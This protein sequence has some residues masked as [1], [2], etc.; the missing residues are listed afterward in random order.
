MLARIKQ[1]I[2]GSEFTR[3]VLTLMSGTTIAQFIPFLVSPII[4]RLYTPE[5]M[6]V[7]TLYLGLVNLLAPVITGTYEHAI[8]LPKD[9]DDAIHV[10]SLSGIFVLAASLLSLL[11]FIIFNEPI[12]VQLKNPAI[13]AWLYIV[14]L[15]IFLLSAYS[16]FTF[17]SMRRK[18][19]R[20]IAG[21]RVTQSIGTSA[22][23]IATSPLGA[24]GLVIGVLVGQGLATGALALPSWKKDNLKEK[25]LS[26]QKMADNAKTYAD[27][28]KYTM[29]QT[30]L[31]GVNESG[32]VFLITSLFVQ[33]TLGSYGFAIKI[34]KAPLNFI[35]K[36][37]G[38]VFYQKAAETYNRGG[39]LWKLLRDVLLRLILIAAPILLVLLAFG[40]QLFSFIFGEKWLDAGRYAQILA[41][42]MLVQ[43]VSSP[44]SQIPLILKKQ[45]IYLLVGAGYN[46][47]VPIS[48]AIAAFLT[49]NI[50][51]SLMTVSVTA[52]VYL[53]GIIS[54]FARLT[55]AH[56]YQKED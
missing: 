37:F 7:L 43:F 4:S 54:W 31:D 28:P 18:E 49:H 16:I 47:S 38:Q 25:R 48:F 41:P 21:S 36:S 1:Q 11:V 29:P 27:F 10:A 34:L 13:S 9:E 56:S 5:D 42:W 8:M 2:I 23:Q 50:E 15:G 14:P 32:L 26:R 33:G 22:L 46:L 55:K 12:T 51:I 3:N 6:D 20:R 45:K 17:W 35:G 30:L 24:S 40:P 53:I 19:Y 44:V 39:D 52:C